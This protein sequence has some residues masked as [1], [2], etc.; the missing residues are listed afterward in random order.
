MPIRNLPGK[1]WLLDLGSTGSVPILVGVHPYPSAKCSF[2]SK[3]N[4]EKRFIHHGFSRPLL[5]LSLPTFREAKPSRKGGK[6]RL[7]HSSNWSVLVMSLQLVQGAVCAVPI[8]TGSTL[9]TSLVSDGNGT[10]PRSKQTQKEPGLSLSMQKI[11]PAYAYSSVFDYRTEHRSSAWLRVARIRGLVF[12][13]ESNAPLCPFLLLG[14]REKRC[15]KLNHL[16]SN[17]LIKC[18]EAKPLAFDA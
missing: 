6:T 18:Q 16:P 12:V 3:V 15:A 2:L 7:P 5:P 9:L 11:P 10:A 8:G 14:Q 1:G 17:T 4:K 13:I